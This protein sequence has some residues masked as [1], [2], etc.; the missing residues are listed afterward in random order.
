MIRLWGCPP[1]LILAVLLEPVPEG[2]HH[3]V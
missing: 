1:D 2:D 3:V